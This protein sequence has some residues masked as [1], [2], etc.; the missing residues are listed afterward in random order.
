MKPLWIPGT[1]CGYHALTFGF[2]VDQIV[3]RL[4]PRK[5]GV[6]QILREDILEKYGVKDISIGL[7]DEQSNLRV[8]TVV[9]QTS[10]GLEVERKLSPEGYNNPKK[11]CLKMP[12]NM[13]IGTARGLAELHS[14]LARGKLLPSDMLE[15][16]ST[17]QIINE[18]DIIN[19]YPENK[20]FGWQYSKNK[21]GNWNFGHSGHGGQIVRVD[22]ETGLS[23]AYLCNGLKSS[24]SDHVLPFRRL[25]EALYDCVL[26]IQAIF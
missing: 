23:Y 8:A 17:P 14:I 10:E 11:R 6:E 21:L 3:R 13:G 12:S 25:Q 20:G 4:D 26:E 15:L 22:L 19:G 1:K 16:I 7:P 5:R 24:D 9:Q 18:M 2:L